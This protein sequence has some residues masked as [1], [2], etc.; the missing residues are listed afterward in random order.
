[1]GEYFSLLCIKSGKCFKRKLY[2]CYLNIKKPYKLFFK[3]SKSTLLKNKI[4]ITYVG[5]KIAIHDEKYLNAKDVAIVL[6]QL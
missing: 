4:I 3:L 2:V 6:L 1:M 5:G